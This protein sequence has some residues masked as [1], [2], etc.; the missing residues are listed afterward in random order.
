MAARLQFKPKMHKIVELLLY[1]SHKMQHVDHYKACKLVYLADL[2]HLNTYGRPLVA[3]VPK[4]MSYGPVATKSYELLKEEPEALEQAG[5]KA[6]PFELQKL[7]KIII[8][9]KPHRP[10]DRK[11]FSKSDI[12]VF[13]EVLAEFGGLSFAQLHE[14]TSQ[15]FAY[16]NAWNGR[17]EKQKAVP[18]SFD[19]MLDERE[20][21]EAFIDDI[22]PVSQK[23]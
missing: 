23:M 1:L 20:D 14:V 11:L 9:G 7:D 22:G 2:R 19:D 16:R 13:D 6:L 18:M 15:H 3:D 4:A 8:I 5:I 12:Q 21:K 17:S 10:V